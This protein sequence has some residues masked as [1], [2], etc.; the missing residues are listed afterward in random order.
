M[1]SIHARFALQRG[2]FELNATFEAPV[3]GVTAVFGPSGSGK[4]TL[5]NCI[6]GLEPDVHGTLR[7]NG[8]TWQD[9]GARVFLP[10]HRRRVGYVFQD[11]GLLAHLSVRG[12]L[13]YGMK[14]AYPVRSWP[15]FDQAVEAAGIGQLL[16]RR[17]HR[18]SGGERSRVAMAR[19]LLTD[20]A[21]LLMDEPLAA[22][23]AGARSD[24]LPY[25]ERLHRQLSIP[26]LYVS[27]AIDEVARLADH[28]ISLEA[29]QITAAGPL[30]DMLTR[31]DL[32]L[33]HSDEASAVLE[34][35]VTGHDE[36]FQ[37]A[38][39][40]FP[41]GRLVVPENQLP[42]GSVVRVRILA[43]DV[44]LSLERH[45]NTSILNVF[46]A[47]IVA[48]MEGRT[49]QAVVKLDASGVMLLARITR[50]SVHALGLQPGVEI[51]AQVKSV[52]LLR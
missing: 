43:R 8:E 36:K 14:R 39:L 48:I 45:N 22:L 44:S 33:A 9:S 20:P 1:S 4:S 46:P 11:A 16:E 42:E 10:A 40:E 26:V 23:D 32:P 19:A 2:A 35:V 41:A 6:A 50:R 25:L 28:M 24:I 30:A 12:N 3:R 13:E 52:A 38:I 5:L 29:G 27:H 7:V 34:A 15:V 37:L 51:F 49:A 17:I 18:L 21:I 47:R 31:L